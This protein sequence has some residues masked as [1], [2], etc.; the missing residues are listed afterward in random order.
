[1][2]HR[3]VSLIRTSNSDGAT[4]G[5][6]VFVC[7][8]GQLAEGKDGESWSITDSDDGQLARTITPSVNWPGH[9]H[10]FYRNV[11]YTTLD[12]L[13]PQVV[14]GAPS[15]ANVPDYEGRS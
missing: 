15:P 5:R 1:M 10:D 14:S 2:T 3:L 7:S 11:P 4:P 6:P 12:S 9:F 8:C 13:F